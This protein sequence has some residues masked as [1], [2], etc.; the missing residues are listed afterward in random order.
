MSYFTRNGHSVLLPGAGRRPSPCATTIFC[1][2][3]GPRPTPNRLYLWSGMI[4]PNGHCRDWIAGGDFNPADYKPV[5]DLRPPTNDA[6]AVGRHLLAGLRQRRGRLH[7]DGRDTSKVY[8]G[9]QPATGCF[10]GLRT[11]PSR[12]PPIAKVR[13]LALSEPSLR[14]QCETPDSGLGKNVKTTCWRA[15]RGR[16]AER[17]A[18]RYAA[19]G[20]L[21]GCALRHTPSTRT[22]SAGWTARAYTA[23]VLI[24]ALCRQARNSGPGLRCSS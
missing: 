23:G 20:V 13:Q 4:D 12:P 2:G 5:Y 19:A 3:A 15:I 24:E 18:G 6:A 10:N 14:A 8:Y 7:G 1:L 9:A 11:I 21:G 22:A 16:T 17:R